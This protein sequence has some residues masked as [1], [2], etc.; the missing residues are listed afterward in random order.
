MGRFRIRAVA[1][2][3][4]FDLLAANGECILTSEVYA[5]AAACR[6]GIASVQ[7]NTALAA[8]E[9]L[10][11]QEGASPANPKF[12]IYQDR[13]GQYRFRLKARNG[14]TIATSQGYAAKGSCLQ[15][16]QSVRGNAPTAET[17]E[18]A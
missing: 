8:V 15:G 11:Q 12:Q 1:S 6:K 9:D 18:D 2:G 10:T 13:G 16:L 5:S 14:E 7:R 3:V 17:I 4:K